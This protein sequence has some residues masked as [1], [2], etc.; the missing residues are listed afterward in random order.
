MKVK[1]MA[2]SA[3]CFSNQT[4]TNTTSSDFSVVN[5]A[6]SCVVIYFPIPSATGIDESL[7]PPEFQA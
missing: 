7:V 5:S 4:N 2:A 3:F 1:R 6:T